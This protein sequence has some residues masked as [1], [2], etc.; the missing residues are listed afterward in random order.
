MK[1]EQ[2]IDHFFRSDSVSDCAVGEFSTGVV[3]DRDRVMFGSSVGGT[4]NPKTVTFI[5]WPVSSTKR[6]LN[7][8][9][10]FSLD[11]GSISAQNT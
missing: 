9:P 1:S 6:T 8:D 5:S 7:N 2:H 3:Y 4:T 11:A 10:G